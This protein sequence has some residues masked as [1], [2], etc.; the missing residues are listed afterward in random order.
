M[1]WFLTL[2]VKIALNI[3]KLDVLLIYVWQ[4]SV[5]N[6]PA[7]VFKILLLRPKLPHNWSCCFLGCHFHSVPVERR[8]ENCD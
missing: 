6:I 1:I 4:A 5:E 3:F 8:K 7:I 2:E